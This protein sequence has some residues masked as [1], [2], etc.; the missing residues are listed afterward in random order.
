MLKC[1]LFYNNQSCHEALV[2]FFNDAVFFS[3]STSGSD[4][5]RYRVSLFGFVKRQ[6]SVGRN[7]IIF[8]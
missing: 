1:N 8:Q 3:S 4:P 7:R 6:H 2:V 5:L